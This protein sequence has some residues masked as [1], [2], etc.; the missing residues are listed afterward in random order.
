MHP[1]LLELSDHGSQCVKMVPV[2]LILQMNLQ[3]YKHY[4]LI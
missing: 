3:S 2:V 4:G 1:S